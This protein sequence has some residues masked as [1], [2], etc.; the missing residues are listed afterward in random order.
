VDENWEGSAEPLFRDI[1]ATLRRPVTLGDRAVEA[2]LKQLRRETRRA[3]WIRRVAGAAGLAAALLLV[4]A[5]V[6]SRNRR[7]GAGQVTFTL[8]EPAASRVSLI[9]DFN[10]WNPDANPLRRHDS[11]WSVTL[12]LKPGRYRYSFVVN[13]SSWRADP[14]TPS[15]GDDFGTPSSVITVAN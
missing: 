1:V 9:G 13:G 11:K 10:D 12:R 14:G 7:L 2:A 15:A 5:G 8:A 3:R 6:L 4:L